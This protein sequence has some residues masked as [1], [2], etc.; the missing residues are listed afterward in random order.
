MR[1]EQGELS[2]AA[3]ELRRLQQM[4]TEALAHGAPQDEIDALLERYREA[5]Q[6]YLQILAQNAQPGAGPPAPN[7]K[8]LSQQ[9]L[10]DVA[11]DDPAIGADG[12][13]RS[14]GARCSPCCRTWS[15]TCR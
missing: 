3:A 2:L 1:I 7:A 14:G 13:A 9:D 6:R 12:L 5:L 11:Q 4:L 8:V 15:K 10:E